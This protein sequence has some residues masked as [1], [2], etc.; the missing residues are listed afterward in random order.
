VN[1]NRLSVVS[2]SVAAEL[3]VA[4][5]TIALAGASYLSVRQSKRQ[6]KVLSEQFSIARAQQ[7]PILKLN[8]VKFEGNSLSLSVE[9]I[10]GGPAIWLGLR[11]FFIPARM[12]IFDKQD[13]GTPLDPSQAEEAARQG[14][15]LFMRYDMIHPEPKIVHEGEAVGWESMVSF[16]PNPTT[17]DP[18][19]FPNEQQTV[20]TKPLFLITAHKVFL[21][22]PFDYEQLKALLTANGVQYAAL[23]LG[24]V[25]KD[26]T[27]HPV[28]GRTIGA[29]V[30]DFQRHETLE[31]AAK[32]N[33][34]PYFLAI[35]PETFFKEGWMKGDEYETSKNVDNVSPV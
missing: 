4:L 15:Q 2:L 7:A 32:E 9:N 24:L 3:L 18:T 21:G 28:R 22:A 5:G 25:A 11:T 8:E 12:T 10:G 20:T 35:A 19:L 1:D 26:A 30:A 16:L 27:D 34:R 29:F 14:K 6:L 13:G 31:A 17:N 33:H 23:S